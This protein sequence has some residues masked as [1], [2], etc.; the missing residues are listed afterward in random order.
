MDG[1]LNIRTRDG[2]LTF[3]ELGEEFVR[4]VLTTD[5]LTREFMAAI[6]RGG[7]EA[8]ETV[9]G[10]SVE[11]RGELLNITAKRNGITRL[12]PQPAL[13]GYRFHFLASFRLSLT[14]NIIGGLKEQF[15]LTGSIP[16][17]LEAQAYRPL[18]LYVAYE[19]VR[20]ELI[21][22]QIE[23]GTTCRSAS[24]DSMTRCAA[25]WPTGSTAF[26]PA[27]SCSARSIFWNW[28]AARWRI[29][30]SAMAAEPSRTEDGCRILRAWPPPPSRFPS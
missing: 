16:V 30:P 4:L 14:V 11:Y 26:W 21:D 15:Q 27:T 28:S 19:K 24:A 20:P 13:H 9:D 29:V 17:T 22:L 25:R 7:L 8:V 3:G 12:H 23:K 10:F 1:P 2:R 6:P 18:E 5:L